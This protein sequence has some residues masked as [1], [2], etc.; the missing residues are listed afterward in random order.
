MPFLS[1]IMV[2]RVHI[3]SR[4]FS[5]AQFEICNVQEEVESSLG[6]MKHLWITCVAFLFLSGAF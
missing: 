2:G 1:Y 5:V 6:I 4:H 3:A